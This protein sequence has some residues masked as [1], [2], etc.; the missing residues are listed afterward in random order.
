MWN[1]VKWKGYLDYC[2]SQIEK[3][4]QLVHEMNGDI[5]N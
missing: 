2:F 4:S 1:L 3:I 5:Q